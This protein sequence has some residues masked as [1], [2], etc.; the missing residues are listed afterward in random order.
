MAPTGLTAL[1]PRITLYEDA[2]E[3]IVFGF[4]TVPQLAM[5]WWMD[6]QIHRGNI[7]SDS[8]DADWDC[9]RPQPSD[10]R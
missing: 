2:A 3:N 8:L 5:N 9:L 1:Q 4:G 7:L 10:G 6:S